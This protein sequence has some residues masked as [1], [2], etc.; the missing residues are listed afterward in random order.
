MHGQGMSADNPVIEVIIRHADGTVCRLEGQAAQVWEDWT[1]R[2]VTFATSADNGVEIIE[3][4]WQRSRP[5]IRKP[6]I[7]SQHESLDSGAG[8]PA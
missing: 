6:E 5:K 3:M 1:G 7:R 8:G 2:C 4:E